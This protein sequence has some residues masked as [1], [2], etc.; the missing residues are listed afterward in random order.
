MLSLVASLAACGGGSAPPANSVALVNGVAIPITDFNLFVQQAINQAKAQGQQPPTPGSPQYTAMRNQVVAELVEIAEVKQAA[1]KEG[2]SVTS[3]DVNKF[4]ANLLKTNY[5]GSQEKFDAWLKT[6]GLTMQQAQAE[7]LLNLLAQKLHT[8]ITASAKVTDAQ[9]KAYYTSNI[10]QYAVG[11]ATTRSVEYILRKCNPAA[12]PGTPPVPCTAAQS[13]AA[14]RVADTVEQKLKNGASFE[15]M[16]K[17]YSQDS[18]TAPQ[19][20]KFTLTKGSVVPAFA[21][22]GLA[23]KTGETTS[24]PVDATSVANSYFG[25]FIIKALG[26]VVH[27]KAHTESFKQAQAAIQQNLLT[28]AQDKL[29]QDWLTNLQKSGKV[30]YQAGYAPPATTALPTTT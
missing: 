25:W 5:S 8:K 22:A 10:A 20:G 27:A 14:K 3:S 18:S 15:A 30:T 17:Q 23:L 7:V 13:R 2:V 19:G 11:A 9:E 21:T 4:I 26:P 29:W 6:Q 28:Q 12:A 24:Q 1:P 16:A